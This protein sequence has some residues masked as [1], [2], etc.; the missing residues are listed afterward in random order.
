MQMSIR[1]KG[2][3]LKRYAHT[4]AVVWAKGMYSEVVLFGGKNSDEM[5]SETMVL[6]LGK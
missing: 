6:R 2:K 5:L 3:L 1:Q 4:A